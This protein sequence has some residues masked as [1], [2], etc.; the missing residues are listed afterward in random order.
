MVKIFVKLTKNQLNLAH[1]SSSGIKIH[2]ETESETIFSMDGYITTTV[3]INPTPASSE[4]D[5]PRGNHT[6]T[7]ARTSCGFFA[8]QSITTIMNIGGGNMHALKLSW[9]WSCC[10]L[11]LVSQ[12]QLGWCNYFRS[13]LSES[14]VWSEGNEQEVEHVFL[15]RQFVVHVVMILDGGNDGLGFVLHSEQETAV[16]ELNWIRLGFWSIKF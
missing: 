2:T 3:L 10:S 8:H 9:S 5:D 11:A 12:Q 7:K 1:R 4:E 16:L 14:I 15:S 6:H 13:I